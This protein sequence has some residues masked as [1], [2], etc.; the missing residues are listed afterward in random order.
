MRIASNG[1]PVHNPVMLDDILAERAL[2]ISHKGVSYPIKA[3]A[4]LDIATLILRIAKIL[5]KRLKLGASNP[6]VIL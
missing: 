3:R 4:L 2:M 6:F 1:Q 5:S